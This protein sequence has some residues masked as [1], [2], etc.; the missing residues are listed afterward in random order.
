MKKIITLIL[1]ILLFTFHYGQNYGNIWYFGKN[2][3]LDFNG[4]APVALTNGANAG[5]EGTATICDASG[6]FL[7]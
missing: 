1:S 2:A 5:Y 4:C 6:Q 3:G 7:F